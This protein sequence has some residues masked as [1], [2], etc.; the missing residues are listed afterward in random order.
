MSLSLRYPAISV[1]ETGPA[2]ETLTSVTVDDPEG[3]P[4]YAAR[5]VQ[6][7][8]VGPSPQWLKGTLEA[9]GLRSINN[10]VD[11]TNYVL[12]EMGQPL[13]GFDFDRLR[14]QRIVVRLA[15]GGER[16]TTLDGVERTL[17]DDTLLICDGLGPVAIA[18]IMGG[19]DSEITPQTRRVLIE[20]A[21]FQPRAIR[22]SSKKL[23]LRTESSYRFERGVDPE[24]VIRALDRA[25]QLMMEVGG[26]EIA[27]E[28]IDVYPGPSKAA[29]LTLRVDRVNRFLGTQLEASEMAEV[30]NRIEMQARQYDV[31]RLLVEVPSFRPDVTREVDLAEEVARLVGYD[32]IPITTPQAN[33][34]AAPLDPHLRIRHE[35][36]NAL[37]GSGFLEVLTYSFISFDSLQKLR[38]SPEDPRLRP[39][40]LLNPLSEEQG[41]MRTSLLPGLL[42]TAHHN[43]DHR[44]EDLRIFELSK[45]FLPRDGE[46]LPQEPHHLAGLMAGKLFPQSLYGGEEEIGYV[47]V[48]GVVET[49]LDLFCIQRVQF[50][51]EALPSYLDERQAS[52]LFLGQ[53][54]LGAMGLLHPE[55]L[56]AFDLKKPAY[57]FYLDFDKLFEAREP[58]ALF[59]PLPKFP[60]VARDMALVVDEDLPVQRPMDFILDQREPLLERSGGF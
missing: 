60:S 34:S 18:G 17:F 14:E 20:S 22:R 57:V 29:P 10:I 44:N 40:R 4:R 15:R 38:L 55:V 52:S 36:K 11:V 43:F 51:P 54:R 9:V 24:G 12:M 13:H 6:G 32:R 33:V 45:V 41:V 35:V 37:Q 31:D 48:K 2:A 19:L 23:G 50:R 46:S 3:C 59:R 39:I 58:R 28:R 27:R 21:Y 30:L 26:G 56:D 25:A 49:I 1:L 5:I 47:D 53:E 16:F 42:N 7:V 8:T